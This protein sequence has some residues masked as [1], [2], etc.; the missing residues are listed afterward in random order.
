MLKESPSLIEKIA[1]GHKKLNELQ[2][3]AMNHKLL[4][5]GPVKD[6]IPSKGIIVQ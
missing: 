1:A 2:N 3:R 4:F 6:I 5:A